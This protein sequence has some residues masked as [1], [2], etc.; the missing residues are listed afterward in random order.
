MSTVQEIYTKTIRPLPD[1]E[2]L[3][4][5]TII[6]EEVTKRD[7]TQKGKRGGDI[8]KYIGMF[9]TGGPNSADNEKIDA[10]LA[11][12]YADDHEDED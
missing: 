3:E 9:D 5:A 10:D 8:S 4:I 6:L 7:R 2:K 1:N 12:A 11:R